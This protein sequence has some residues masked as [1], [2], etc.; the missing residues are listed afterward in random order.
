MTTVQLFVFYQH[1]F[2][3]GMNCQIHVL[4]MHGQTIVLVFCLQ[5]Q[6]AIHII[7]FLACMQ[8]CCECDVRFTFLRSVWVHWLPFFSASRSSLEACAIAAALMASS[9]SVLLWF[10]I[11]MRISAFVTSVV[12]EPCPLLLLELWMFFKHTVSSTAEHQLCHHFN[13]SLQFPRSILIVFWWL[14]CLYSSSQMTLTLPYIFFWPEGRIPRHQQHWPSR[15]Q[16]EKF[17]PIYS[18]TQHSLP[19]VRWSFAFHK[20]RFAF[21]QNNSLWRRFS[22]P[23]FWMLLGEVWY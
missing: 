23:V 17:G 18:T 1:S 12:F 22:L 5:H 2:R 19:H 14:P 6:T 3:C 4:V 13:F 7:A 16:S 20:V 8:H 9:W 21:K 15:M 10:P 11:A